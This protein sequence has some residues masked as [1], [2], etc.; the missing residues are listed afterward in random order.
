M[1]GKKKQLKNVDPDCRHLPQLHSTM[2]YACL[3]WR[4]RASKRCPLEESKTSEG[5][6]E[7]KKGE[8]R[9]N[10]K[11]KKEKRKEKKRRK[12]H[13]KK[14]V[15]HVA[16]VKPQDGKIACHAA[17]V[18]PQDDQ[19]VWHMAWVKPQDDQIVCHAAWVKLQDDQTGNVD[20]G[21]NSIFTA[22]AH[23]SVSLCV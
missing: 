9:Q 18:K 4:T 10:L 15:C 2:V 23:A 12:N 20:C 13:K 1:L 6:E 5:K 17:W 7:R 8:K 19:I 22:R 16:W 3:H 14:I 21:G 11:T